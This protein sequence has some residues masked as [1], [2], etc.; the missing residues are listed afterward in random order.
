MARGIDEF[1][2]LP[3]EGGGVGVGVEA[4]ASGSASDAPDTA[5]AYT[6]ATPIPGPS[7]LQGEGRR[8]T[9]AA[10]ARALR[11][12][13]HETYGER[14]VWKAL[15]ERRMNFRRQAPVGPYVVDFA[16]FGSRLIVEIDGYHHTL[17]ERQA[18][19]AQRDAWFR[20]A[21]FRVLRIDETALKRDLMAVVEQ[22]VAETAPPPSPTLPP[23]RGK[24][25]PRYDVR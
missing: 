23:S 3:L 14:I 1:E 13:K 12:R 15:R 5:L 24:G 22:I 20:T 2:P 9:P 16:H 11:L 17:P 18:R 10:K 4:P 21:G 19:D 8:P 6:V 25:A 7:P